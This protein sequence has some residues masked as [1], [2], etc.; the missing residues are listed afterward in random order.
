[1]NRQK[2]KNFFIVLAVFAWFVFIY[3]WY[4]FYVNT[5]LE[6]RQVTNWNRVLYSMLTIAGI[7]GIIFIVLLFFVG[8][9]QE[10]GLRRG[11]YLL[12]GSLFLLLSASWILILQD[13]EWI[14]LAVLALNLVG[15]FV[16]AFVEKK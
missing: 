10:D 1:M 11:Q 12:L 4:E 15:I 14:R 8:K 5:L 7:G 16:A 13:N 3:N 9:K 2:Y 6:S